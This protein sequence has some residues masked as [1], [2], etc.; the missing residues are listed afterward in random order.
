MSQKFWRVRV[1]T[2]DAY[3][4]SASQSR[5][6]YARD[7]AIKKSIIRPGLL[8]T[9]KMHNGDIFAESFIRW[10]I[11]ICCTRRH[12]E[13]EGYT[14]PIGEKVIEQSLIAAYHHPINLKIKSIH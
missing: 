12:I 13:S 7:T 1:P 10:S 3:T 9:G 4:K 11:T 5:D 8:A 6:K 2:T 14:V